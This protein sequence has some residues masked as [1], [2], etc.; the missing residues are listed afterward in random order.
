LAAKTRSES[1][2]CPINKW[3]KLWNRIK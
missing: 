2:E 3:W 1:S